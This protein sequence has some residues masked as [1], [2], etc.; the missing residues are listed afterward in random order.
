MG[1]RLGL[2]TRLNFWTQCFFLHS[3]QLNCCDHG[4]KM[5]T[6]NEKRKESDEQSGSG[7]QHKKREISGDTTKS[8][9]RPQFIRVQMSENTRKLAGLTSPELL[10]IHQVRYLAGMATDISYIY[11]IVSRVLETTE[12]A[13]KLYV[14]R[15]GRSRPEEAEGWMAVGKRDVIDGGTYLCV[16]RE[17][18]SPYHVETNHR[19]TETCFGRSRAHSSWRWWNVAK[20]ERTFLTASQSTRVPVEAI[21]CKLICKRRPRIDSSSEP[22]ETR[23]LAK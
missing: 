6:K 7:R 10:C 2:G 11:D 20:I 14:R 1:T 19:V 21:H 5:S 12:D 3:A 13:V 15:D 22:I 9:D 17:G 16:V 4:L 23:C 18:I 8:R